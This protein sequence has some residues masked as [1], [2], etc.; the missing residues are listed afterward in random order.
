MARAAML[1]YCV[2]GDA[3]DVRPDEIKVG[4]HCGNR[5]SGDQPPCHRTRRKRDR[6]GN[7]HERMGRGKRHD[8]SEISCSILA[9]WVA[10][11]KCEVA[12]G[13]RLVFVHRQDAE[14]QAFAAPIEE[15]ACPF[16]R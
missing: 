16:A 13:R 9:A 5:G 1:E 4:Q 12:I 10:F 3:E 8:V 6:P 11:S 14:G 7:R 15:R 2:T